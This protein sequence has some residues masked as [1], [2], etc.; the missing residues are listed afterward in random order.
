[1]HFRLLIGLLNY[2]FFCPTYVI[3]DGGLMICHIYFSFQSLYNLLLGNTP[4]TIFFVCLFYYIQ[5]I[6]C[7]LNKIS[8]LGVHSR[9]FHI[10]QLI[11]SPQVLNSP[12]HF[13]L[14]TVLLLGTDLT[15]RFAILKVS[16]VIAR[17]WESRTDPYWLHVIKG[18]ET[19]G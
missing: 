17:L 10:H 19:L 18:Q 6:H 13:P 4:N 16:Q 11:P 8:H 7:T 14:C 9:S 1:M 15:L 12:I 2:T 5:G 3:L